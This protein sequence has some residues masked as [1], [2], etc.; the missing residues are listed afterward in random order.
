MPNLF[1][2]SAALTIA[3]RQTEAAVPTPIT[4]RKFSN[5]RIEFDISKTS[6]IE[7]NSAEIIIYNINDNSRSS[8]QEADFAI[9]DIGYNGSLDQIFLGDIKRSTTQRVGPDFLTLLELGDGQKAL[10]ESTM[11]K[12]YAEGVDL[13]T[14]VLDSLDVMRESA[15]LIVENAKEF[16]ANQPTIKEQA[17]F[18]ASGLA[19]NTIDKALGKMDLEWSI[20][21]NQMQ[22]ITPNTALET[23]A[24]A[25]LLSPKTGLI[26]SP[27]RKKEGIVL[28]ALIQST[29]VKPKSLIK[30]ES[31]EINGFFTVEKAQFI[32][33]T[34]GSQW[35]MK[36]EA[37]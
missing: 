19:R 5:F 30:V 18:A 10:Q 3:S 2:R 24:E 28:Q 35:L 22:I 29:R 1:I 13:K 26:G 34:H 37:I 12:G 6:D 4:G 23:R 21:D 20:Q 32:G 11:D 33:D 27:I 9:L 7:Q 14:V 16:M 17:G 31:R 25:L 8:I 36:M 15:G